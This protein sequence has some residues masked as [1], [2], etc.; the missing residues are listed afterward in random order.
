MITLAKDQ[1]VLLM[2]KRIE[3]LNFQS[4]KNIAINDNLMTINDN[5]EQ[6]Y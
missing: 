5:F 4:T 2:D 1:Y 3:L 6:E